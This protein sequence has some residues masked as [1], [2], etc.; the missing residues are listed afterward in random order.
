MANRQ[1][2][3]SSLVPYITAWSEE[4]AL[5]TTIVE[6]PNRGIVYVDE[7]FGDRDQHGV[8]WPRMPSRP[9]H[10]RPEFGRVHSLRQRRAMRQLLCQVCGTPADH[11]DQGVLW[12]LLD[13]HGDWPN[14]PEHMACTHPP[15]CA[16]CARIAARACPA[17]RKAPLAVRVRHCPIVGVLGAEY[18]PGQPLPTVARQAIVAFDNPAIRW[19]Q[20]EQLIRQLN[21]CT[22]VDLDQL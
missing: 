3:S 22:I 10:G 6:V 8:L 20:A 21:D 5:P 4:Q 16:R 7:A 19:T 2:R 17:L 1:D 15:V 18:P 9:G 14:W 12:L 13:H 11:N